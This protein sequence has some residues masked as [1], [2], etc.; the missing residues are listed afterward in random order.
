M[1]SDTSDTSE[2]SAREDHASTRTATKLIIELTI[3]AD[4]FLLAETL[5]EYPDR[6]VEFEQLVPTHEQILP[7]LWA[8]GGGDSGF[9]AALAAD[10]TVARCR[11]VAELDDGALYE[12]E[13]ADDE[14][15][16]LDWIRDR[17]ATLLQSE[18]EDGEWILKLRVESRDALRDLQEFCDERDVAFDLIRLYELRDPKIG[19]FNVTEKQ[20]EILIVALDMGFFEIPRAATL[21]EVADAVGISK[22]AASERLRRGHTNL[23]SNTLTIGQPTGIGLG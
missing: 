4:A 8:T 14:N 1:P 3:P 15:G 17:G 16:L 2:R 11:P 12:I 18:G 21:A 7:Y 22:R 19:Q 23:V 20:R 5:R 13:W 6:I 10:S 9:E